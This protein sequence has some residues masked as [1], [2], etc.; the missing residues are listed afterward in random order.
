MGPRLVYYHVAKDYLPEEARYMIRYHS[1]YPAHQEGEYEYLM[2]ARD[3]TMFKW[4]CEFQNYDLYSKSQKRPNLQEIRPYYEHLIA[5]YFR[6]RFRGRDQR[7]QNHRL[8]MTF[9]SV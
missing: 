3:K 5:E 8:M 7:S 2:S 6:H 4:V 1:F 9:C